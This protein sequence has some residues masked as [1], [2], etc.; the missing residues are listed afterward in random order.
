MLRT[1]TRRRSI[2]TVTEASRSTGSVAGQPLADR[3]SAQTDAQLR[4]LIE[5]CT[6]ILTARASAA[7]QG[8]FA[9][10]RDAAAFLIDVSVG[11]EEHDDDLVTGALQQLSKLDRATA[12][13]VK[14]IEDLVGS[15]SNTAW[16][17]NYDEFDDEGERYD[18]EAEQERDYERLQ[19]A[20]ARLGFK[21]N[22]KGMLVK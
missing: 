6:E 18:A 7:K 16:M 21:F 11:D 17:L 12:Q 19:Q 13:N 3:L 2:H 4:K 9:T 22:K 14:R 10:P 8:S 5:M 15:M 1:E 20:L